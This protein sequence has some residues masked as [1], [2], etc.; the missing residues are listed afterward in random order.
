MRKLSPGEP[1]PPNWLPY[2]MVE[3]VDATTAKVQSGGGAVY[4]P[5]N[6]MEGVGRFA[7]LADPQGAVFALYKSHH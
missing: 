1:A 4:M 3:D 6:T 5:P 2:F 7:V